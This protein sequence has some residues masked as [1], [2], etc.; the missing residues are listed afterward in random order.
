MERGRWQTPKRNLRVGCGVRYV[1]AKVNWVV[2][3]ELHSLESD[4]LRIRQVLRS[5][6]QSRPR[7]PRLYL[8]GL[9]N[10]VVE[11]HAPVAALSSRCLRYH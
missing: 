5:K 3:S 2:R 11:I 6:E 1:I 9:C 10:N 8:N 4:A 7:L